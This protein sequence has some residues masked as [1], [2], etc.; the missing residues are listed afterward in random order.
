VQRTAPQTHQKRSQRSSNSH[1]APFSVA[2]VE[3]HHQN[4]RNRRAFTRVQRALWMHKILRTIIET[5]EE[6]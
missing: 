6:E 1:Q 4:K 2:D 5:K 3:L